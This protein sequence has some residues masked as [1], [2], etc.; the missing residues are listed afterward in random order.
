[1]RFNLERKG[2]LCVCCLHLALRILNSSMVL[3]R[4]QA[5]YGSQTQDSRESPENYR[6]VNQQSPLGGDN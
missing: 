1:M 6:V 4:K 5:E 2:E 3:E